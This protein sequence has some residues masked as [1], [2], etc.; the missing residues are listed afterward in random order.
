MYDEVSM[1]TG[2]FKSA[3][4]VGGRWES[5]QEEEKAVAAAETE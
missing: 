3:S 5:K 2:K 4:C 1:A